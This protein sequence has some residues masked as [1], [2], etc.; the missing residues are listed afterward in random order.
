MSKLIAIVLL[1]IPFG[2][3]FFY[4]VHVDGLAKAITFFA[5]WLATMLCIILAI[6]LWN[7]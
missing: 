4:V 5:V 7:K 3:L 2:A 1:A 6:H